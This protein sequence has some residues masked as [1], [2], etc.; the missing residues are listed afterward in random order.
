[1]AYPFKYLINQTL[2]ATTPGEVIKIPLAM[3]NWESPSQCLD[4]TSQNITHELDLDITSSWSYVVCQYYP[5]AENAIPSNNLLPP[6]KATGRNDICNL[7][8]KYESKSYNQTTE[9]WQNYLGTS[10]AQ[11]NNT[12]RLVILQGGYDRVQGI[13]TPDLTLTSD[14]QH[15]RVILTPG[16]PLQH[17]HLENQA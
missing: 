14:R 1:M 16:K 7:G 13:G 5:I 9:F 12:T 6:L 8:P 3:T 11:I 4:W 15:S 2:N 17:M 10:N